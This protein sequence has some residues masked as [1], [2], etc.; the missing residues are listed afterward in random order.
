MGPRPL[1]PSPAG[2]VANRHPTRR[3]TGSSTGLHGPGESHEV[4]QDSRTPHRPVSNRSPLD[5]KTRTLHIHILPSQIHTM[6][7]HVLAYTELPR[8]SLSRNR[9]P[10]ARWSHPTGA[11]VCGT[12][13]HSERRT[14][15]QYRHYCWSPAQGIAT[16]TRSPCDFR[17]WQGT[18]THSL[19]QQ[20][21][22]T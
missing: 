8:Q 9:H 20:H 18:Y 22:S 3:C 13:T 16:S 6:Q 4:S 17:P 11:Q 7:Y 15:S 5:S 1:P 14:P 21:T 12:H 10:S 2:L 19:G